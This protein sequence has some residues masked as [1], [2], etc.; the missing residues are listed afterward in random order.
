MR[1]F[2]NGDNAL[3]VACGGQVFV[4]P[5]SIVNFDALLDSNQISMRSIGYMLNV[6]LQRLS[7]HK[8]GLLRK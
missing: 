5:A 4:Q 2:A 8:T 1:R 7:I 3:Y 6:I